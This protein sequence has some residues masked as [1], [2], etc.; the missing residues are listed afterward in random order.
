MTTPKLSILIAEI[1]K[2]LIV[3]EQ[4][5]RTTTNGDAVRPTISQARDAFHQNGFVTEVS[6]LD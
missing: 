6:R 5:A 1:Q 2:K 3:A 4:L